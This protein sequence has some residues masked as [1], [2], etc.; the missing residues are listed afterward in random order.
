MFFVKYIFLLLF[1]FI[2]LSSVSRADCFFCDD[3]EVNNTKVVIQQDKPV[4]KTYNDELK[5]VNAD[6]SGLTVKKERKDFAK[7]STIETEQKVNLLGLVEVLD[8][9]LKN[10][11]KLKQQYLNVDIA[12]KDYGIGKSA[13]FPNLDGSVSYGL[14]Q[15][16]GDKG[17][18]DSNKF[19]ASVT[20]SYL[21]FDFGKREANISALK[22]RVIAM[23]YQS[24]AFLQNFIFD[25]I[26]VYYDL[27]L[28]IAS[29]NTARETQFSSRESYKAA[30]TKYELG[31]VA[32]TDKLQAETSY[33]QSVLN[34]NVAENNVTIAKA[35]LSNLLNLPPNY[36]LTLASPILDM[37]SDFLDVDIAD[38]IDIAI[39]NRPDIKYNEKQKEIEKKN[40]WIAKSEVLPTFNLSASYVLSEDFK[41]D[42]TKANVFEAGVGVKVPFFTG[43][44]IV[45]NIAKSK[46]QLKMAEEELFKVKRDVELDVWT[47]YQNFLTSKKNFSTSILILKSATETEKNVFGRYKNGRSSMLDL[48]SAQ[49]DL[50]N[51]KY[52][53]VEAQY[54]WFIQRANLIRS[55]GYMTFQKVQQIAIINMEGLDD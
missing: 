42:E 51:A 22:E 26:K 28:A 1:V 30:N 54:N 52:S 48:L 49:V 16:D 11:P 29:E 7:P 44:R 10:N 37:S 53:Y 43:G 36:V 25:V 3:T 41:K 20:L 46:L 32:L 24:N 19:S 47:S 8:I 23:D 13:W 35:K 38:L 9:A 14:S 5:K 33:Q 27:L 2:S 45:N 21:L 18:D 6:D 55:L 40:V 17:K 4:S 34:L 31:V 50:A 39:K 12:S 15:T